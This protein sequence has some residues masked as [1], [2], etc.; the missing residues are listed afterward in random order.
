MKV[1]ILRDWPVHVS[2]AVTVWY[3][4]AVEPI[5]APRVHIEALVAAGAGQRIE[6]S[7]DAAPPAPE[8]DPPDEAA[9]FAATE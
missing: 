4:R 9:L 7:A 5:T 6:E 3:H 1:R 2:E 8:T